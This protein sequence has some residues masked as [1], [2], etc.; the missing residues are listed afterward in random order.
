MIKIS[1]VIP[2]G[3]EDE[4]RVALVCEIIRKA[5][6]EQFK[7]QEGQ[8]KKLSITLTEDVGGNGYSVVVS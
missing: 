1:C 3:A 6:S 8:V 5:I 7:V 2:D 4:K